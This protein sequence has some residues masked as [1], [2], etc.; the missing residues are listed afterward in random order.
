MAAGATQV[1]VPAITG[2]SAGDPI[3]VDGEANTI[4]TTATGTL[5]LA[6]PLRAAHD[7]GKTVVGY[8]RAGFGS[9]RYVTVQQRDFATRLKWT[10][11]P[12]FAGA[13]HAPQV[14]VNGLDRRAGAGDH[15]AE[16]RHIGSHDSHD[17]E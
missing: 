7:A 15:R 13:N 3:V 1:R 16:L 9:N 6:A 12:T 11:T 14:A 8:G 5:N 17:S 10:V 4:T 2:F